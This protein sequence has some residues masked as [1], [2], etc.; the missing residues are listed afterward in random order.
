MRASANAKAVKSSKPKSKRRGWGRFFY[1]LLLILLAFIVGGFLSFAYTVDNQVPPSPVP[2]ADGIVVWTGKGGGRLTSGAALLAGGHGERLLISG[3]NEKNTREDVLKLL[4]LDPV[5]ADC[6]VDLDYA[7]YDTVGNARE[8]AIWSEALGYEHIILVTS[9]YH[10]PRA[11]IEIAAA[12][13][14]IR[15]TPYAVLAP[16]TPKWWEDGGR[17]RR[18]LQEYGKLLL[19]YVRRT[20][21]GSNR[22]TPVIDAIPDPDTAADQPE[23]ATSPSP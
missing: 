23:N 4:S 14:R 19:T 22:G 9:A 1:Y 12:R 17:F 5:L 2:N 13:G 8:T 7:A 18:M 3:V 20:A 16:G 11:E 21:T 6:C 10:M 15:I